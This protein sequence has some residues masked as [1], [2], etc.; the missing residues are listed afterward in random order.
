VTSPRHTFVVTVHEDGQ[1]AVVEDVRTGAH[2]RVEDL[3]RVGEQI[4][5][6]LAD[7]GPQRPADGNVLRGGAARAARLL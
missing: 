2:A 4:A 7:A 3:A 5:A 6:W 1:V